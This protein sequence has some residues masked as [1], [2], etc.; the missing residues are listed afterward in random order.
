[1]LVVSQKVTYMYFL[2]NLKVTVIFICMYVSSV[3]LDCC[4]V[5][6]VLLRQNCSKVLLH[7]V[8]ICP[9][10]EQQPIVDNKIYCNNFIE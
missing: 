8:V 1:M 10:N 7:V 2:S 6:R 4:I 9:R 5:M 3:G